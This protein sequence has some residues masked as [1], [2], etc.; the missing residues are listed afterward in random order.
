MSYCSMRRTTPLARQV[1]ERIL[2]LRLKRHLTQEAL[3][4]RAGV[5]RNSVYFAERGEVLPTLYTLDAFAKA[6]GVD[7]ADLVSP[8]RRRTRGR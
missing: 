1:G 6:L 2:S 8:G 5:A 7:L 3:A 4:D